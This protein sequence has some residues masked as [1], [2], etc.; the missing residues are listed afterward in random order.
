MELV[1]SSEIL[2]V[3]DGT[4]D[5]PKYIEKGYPLVTSKNLKQGVICFEDVKYVSEEDYNKINNRSKVDEGDILYSMIGSIGNYA[6]VTESPNYAIKNVALFKFK[7][8]NLYNKYFYY[9]LNSPFLENQIKSQQKGG[10]QKFVTLKILRNLKIPL[11]PLDTQ[12]KIAAILDE[13]D[14]LRQLNKQLIETYDALTQSLFLEMFGDPVS[15]PMGWERKSMKSLMKIVRGGS[16]RPIKNF[17]GGKNPW[18]KIGDATKGD[19]IYIYST[20]EHIIDEGLKKTRL[21][22]E[23]SLIFANCG[24]SLGFAR[25]I[26]FQ[27][28]IHDG[29]LAFLE[30]DENVIDKVFLLKALNSVTKYFRDTAP[31]GT[32]PNLNTKIMGD[33]QIILPPIDIQRKFVDSLKIIEQQKDQTQ[34]ALQKS[35]ALFNSLLQKAFKGAL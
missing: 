13:A 20:K 32:Q 4:H 31:D 6:I 2:D 26:K 22:P 14:R 11:P 16:P 35:E 7:D 9:V 27:G 3:R 17:L 34:T 28:C 12:K 23:G 30:F 25:I 33:Y 29:W 15:N 5:S 8:E 21:L 24:V 18:I 10:T 1:L 19:D